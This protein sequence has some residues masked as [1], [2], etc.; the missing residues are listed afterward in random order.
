M[1]ELPHFTFFVR[2]DPS[3]THELYYIGRLLEPVHAQQVEVHV[4]WFEKT[5]ATTYLQSSAVS[6]VSSEAIL[7]KVHPF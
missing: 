5:T 7:C 4:Q 2:T 1:I 6:V 3:E